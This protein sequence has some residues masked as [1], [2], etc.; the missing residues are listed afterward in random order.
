MA[1]RP[2]IG[3]E[4]RVAYSGT[5]P[6]PL[7]E[8]AQKRAHKEKLTFSRLIEWAV[9]AYVDGVEPRRPKAAAPEPEHEPHEVPAMAAPITW[10]ERQDDDGQDDG[11]AGTGNGTGT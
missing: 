11:Q 9:R 3:A 8:R 10:T 6:R 7:L 5:L 2:T 4:K 1:G